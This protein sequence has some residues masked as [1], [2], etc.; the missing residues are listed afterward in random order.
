MEDGDAL[1]FERDPDRV[2]TSDGEYVD[3]TDRKPEGEDEFEDWSVAVDVACCWELEAVL[4]VVSPN[5]RVIESRSVA[6]FSDWECVLLAEGSCDN[7]P[8]ECESL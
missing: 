1:R 5:V 4:D 3:E 8:S 6:V 7:E 2:A